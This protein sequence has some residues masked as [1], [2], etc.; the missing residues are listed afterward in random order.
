VS[1]KQTK[2]EPPQ[3]AIVAW[4]AAGIVAAVLLGVSVIFPSKPAAVPISAEIH[5][6]GAV[7]LLLAGAPDGATSPACGCTHSKVPG[8][9]RG[10]VLPAQ[11]LTV[12][13]EDSEPEGATQYDLSSS[14]TQSLG[15]LPE[16][17][18]INLR[19]AII[20]VRERDLGADPFKLGRGKVMGFSTEQLRT[21]WLSVIANGPLHVE[22][23]AT[24]PVAAL[25]PPENRWATLSYSGSEE[26]PSSETLDVG[27][28][29]NLAASRGG[30]Y[31][32][33]AFPVLDVLGA[34]VTMWAPVGGVKYPYTSAEYSGLI[35]GSPGQRYTVPVH[36][37]PSSSPPRPPRG[38]ATEIVIQTLPPLFAA[39]LAIRP[40]HR[41]SQP[42]V[43][44]SGGAGSGSVVISAP[45]VVRNAAQLVPK[46]A[47]ADRKPKLWIN[48]LPYIPNQ[49]TGPE[50]KV[51][52][53]PGEANYNGR[54]EQ[55]EYPPT[56]PLSGINV[57]GAISDL[58]FSEAT[59][60]LSIGTR[61]QTIS[62][63]TPLELR[64]IK[65]TG[66]VGHHML[67]PV[68]VDGHEAKIHV[69]GE[70]DTRINGLPV[71]SQRPWIARALSDEKV[72]WFLAL[73]SALSIANGIRLSPLRRRR[74]AS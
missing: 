34:A 3:R 53:G 54:S 60:D 1:D 25:S 52:N 56:P 40:I 21:D 6:S 7:S 63:G 65:G 59:A 20:A 37:W 15:A 61:S 11:E 8:G 73:V 30:Y 26:A 14:G 49:Q 71:A 33:N 67:I 47:A 41:R 44:E 42:S 10:I 17:L 12:A 5:R 28:S 24:E 22:S 4:I 29:F 62:A 35:P 39:R 2:A 69:I 51:G 58:R 74:A 45:H 68:R 64:N 9:W 31:G 48:N 13:R 55:F 23:H 57:F 50:R 18:G 38:W 32:A 43:L 72:S 36:E 70:A 46:F 19:V 16:Q 66:I 27:T